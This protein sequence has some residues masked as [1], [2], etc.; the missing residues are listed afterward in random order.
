VKKRSPSPVGHD[1]MRRMNEAAVLDLIKDGAAISRSQLARDSGLSPAAVTRITRGLIQRGLVRETGLSSSSGGRPAVLLELQP[2]AGFVV[3]AKLMENSVAVAIADLSASVLLHRV[4][5]ADIAASGP[6]A[7]AEPIRAALRAAYVPPDRLYG[8]GIG[9]SGVIDAHAG[10]CRYSGILGWRE[11]AVRQPLEK[12][13]GHDVW[14]DNDVNALAIYERWFGAGQNCS[15]L[16]VIT[17][18]RGVGLGIVVNGAFYSGST[19]GA[20]EFGHTTVIENGPRCACGKRGCLEAVVSD[21]GILRLA[22]E[23]G[24]TASSISDVRQAAGAGDARAIAAYQRAGTVLGIGVANLVNVLDPELI[25]I[26]GEGAVAGDLLFEPMRMAIDAHRFASLGRDIRYVVEPA[27][28]DAWAR[29]AASLVLRELF[30]GPVA[31]L[32][33]SDRPRGLRAAGA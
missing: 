18:G 8:I 22:N 16:L 17:V 33:G 15:N 6:Q 27:G 7:A 19:G 5:E 11:V 4:T 1:L 29:G 25:V 24:V 13:L 2:S 3:G 12:A 30:R 20:G 9:L 23:A 31:E 10:I 21:G 14:V 32:V 28:D 26:S